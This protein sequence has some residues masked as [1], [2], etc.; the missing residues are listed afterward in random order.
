MVIQ[1]NEILGVNKNEIM[2]LL[3]IK[4]ENIL[5]RD[6][7]FKSLDVYLFKLEYPQKAGN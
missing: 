1:N 6:A 5:L 2:K 4:L 3:W 7:G